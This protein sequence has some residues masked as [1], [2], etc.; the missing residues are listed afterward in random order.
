MLLALARDPG[1]VRSVTERVIIVGGGV[2]GMCCAYHLSREGRE[3]L[4]LEREAENGNNCS[5]ENAGMVVPSHFTPLAAP[6][7]V[8][9]GLKWLL[10][11]ESP[12]YVRPRLSLELARWGLAFMLHANARHVTASVQLLRDLQLA[13][14]ELFKDLAGEFDFGLQR[15]GLLMLCETEELLKEEVELAARAGELGLR[16]EVCD[17]DR[18]AELDPDVG[19]KARGGIWYEQDCHLDPGRFLQGLKEAAAKKGAQFRYHCVVQEVGDGTVLL[20]SGEELAG[21]EVI[22]AGGAWT[23]SLARSL[24]TRILLQGGKGY[25]LTLDD[26]SALP[27][28]CSLLGE[29]RVAITPMGDSLRV[30]G[31]MEICGNDLSINERRVQGII[32]AACR[33]FPGLN[34]GEFEGVKRWSGLRPCSPDGLPYLGRVEG[35][36][37]VLVASGHAM[38][39]L[40]MGPITGKLVAELVAGRS[41]TIPVDQLAVDRFA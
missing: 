9:Q 24:K 4:V 39:G 28:L 5:R 19:M 38:L 8:T 7:V 3:V 10:D 11:A 15:R 34:P 36:E 27:R 23:D 16:V 31:T 14:R 6:G 26:P 25:S 32:K 1:R 13:S 21:A 33:M 2:I 22:V 18:L 37:K 40:S 17:P 41:P 29:A 30:A 12:F 20:E 35:R